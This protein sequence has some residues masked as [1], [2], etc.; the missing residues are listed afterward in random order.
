MIYNV[1]QLLQESTGARR[2]YAVDDVVRLPLEGEPLAHVDGDV[3]FVRTPRG[4][5][6]HVEIDTEVPSTCARC[7][8]NA[9]VP[10]HLVIDEEFFPTVDPVTSAK[11]PLPDDSVAF[12]ID[13]YHHVDLTDAVRQ[14]AALAEPMQPLCRPDCLGLCPQCGVDRN[15]TGCTCDAPVDSRWSR[16]QELDAL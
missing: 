1:S 5:V 14:A 2:E 8:G 9:R 3:S 4:L 12:L 6:A 13:E 15:Q 11:V 10:M 16:L 7:L